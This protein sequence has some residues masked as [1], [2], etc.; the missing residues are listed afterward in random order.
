MIIQFALQEY[1]H[2]FS[3][4]YGNCILV[5]GIPSFAKFYG[6]A[7]ALEKSKSPLAS[8]ECSEA[9]HFLLLLFFAD[10]GQRKVVGAA[11]GSRT[12]SPAA[13]LVKE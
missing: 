9:R 11:Q 3:K 7:M 10:R 1:F 8:F 13:K 12:I 4:F 5:G 2:L 6:Q